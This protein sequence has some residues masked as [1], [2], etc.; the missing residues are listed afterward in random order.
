MLVGANDRAI[1]TMLLPIDLAC[2]IALLLQ[3]REDTLPYSG[4]HP[5]IKAARDG[6]PRAI[7]FR[8]ISPRRSGIEALGSCDFLVNPWSDGENLLHFPHHC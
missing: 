7:P 3:G 8:Q 5:S 6:A 2:G 1:D 4:F